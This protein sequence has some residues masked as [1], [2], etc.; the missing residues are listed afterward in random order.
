MFR[1]GSAAQMVLSMA[2]LLAAGLTSSAQGAVVPPVTDGLVLGYD[3]SDVAVTGAYVDSWN[4]Q[5][6]GGGAHNA[7]ATGDFRPTLDTVNTLNGHSVVLFDGLYSTTA[8]DMLTT[9]YTPDAGVSFFAVFRRD[10]QTS[11]GSCCRP[12]VTA[13]TLEKAGMYVDQGSSGDYARSRYNNEPGGAGLRVAGVG[14]GQYHVASVT[15]GVGTDNFKLVLD[16]G[17]SHVGTASGDPSFGPV[18]IG[19]GTYT[20]GPRH[21]AGPIAEVLVYDRVLS[22]A[23]RPRVETYLGKKYGLPVA[24][25][26]AAT[27][28]PVTAGL[29]A[30]FDADF[31]GIDASG[32]VDVWKSRTLDGIQATSYGTRPSGELIIGELHGHNVV[33]FN[34]SPNGT[35]G[36]LD[37]LMVTNYTPGAGEDLT[38][39]AVARQS[40]QDY[41]TGSSEIKVIAASGT[42]GSGAGVFRFANRRS[43]KNILEISSHGIEYMAISNDFSDGDFHVMTGSV[44]YG[45]QVWGWY[46]GALTLDQS[47][48]G[49]PPVGAFMIGGDPGNTGRGFSGDIAERPPGRRRDGLAAAAQAAEVIPESSS[50]E[51]RDAQ[52]EPA[53]FHPG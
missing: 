45:A 46:D 39:F 29:K 28:L 42:L 1:L 51:G 11:G 10:A 34:P 21:F 9:T 18:R 5:A 27:D 49:S 26:P 19:G 25:S 31:A 15:A 14:D 41:G 53:G 43:N 22:D 2:I 12:I 47:V 40:G 33:R 52:K 17:T 7:T 16:G 48:S 32:D 37:E 8:G 36:G 23:E 44:D 30:H 13:D 24:S 4:D 35:G 38:V 50:T 20:G 6:A 3:G